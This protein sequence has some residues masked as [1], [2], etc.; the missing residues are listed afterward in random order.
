MHPASAANTNAESHLTLQPLTSWAENPTFR[1]R[2]RVLFRLGQDTR[3][4]HTNTAQIWSNHRN[5]GTD[6]IFA[7][8]EGCKSVADGFNLETCSSS[9]IWLLRCTGFS[10]D[11]M[12]ESLDTPEGKM[13]G[14]NVSRWHS[15]LF[16]DLYSWQLNPCLRQ[17]EPLEQSGAT[18]S[19]CIDD[20]RTLRR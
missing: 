14:L 19:A 7:I 5:H 9:K 1:K 15:I 12:S 11:R 10:D 20:A 17:G 2:T 18:A 6:M 8:A 16:L 3:C 4:N 13:F